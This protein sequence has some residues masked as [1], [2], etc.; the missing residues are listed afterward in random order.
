MTTITLKVPEALAH[1]LGVAAKRQHTSRSALIR[2]AVM[3]YIEDDL[4]DPSQPSTYDLVEA[5]A[6]KAQGPR[7]LST[8]PRHMEGYG[9]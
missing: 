4:P 8:D 6:G 9:T 7:D 1:K 3:K 5:F 2:T